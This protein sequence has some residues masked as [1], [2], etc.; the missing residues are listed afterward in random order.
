MTDLLKPKDDSEA[1]AVFRAQVI[2]PLTCR[3]HS[4]HGELREALRELAEQ[5]VTPPGHA[6]SRCYSLTTLERWYYAFKR[7][8]LAGL[9]PRSRASGFA[10]KLDDQK[11]ELLLEIRREH[12]RVST[13]LILRTIERDGRLLKGSISEPTLRRL[14]IAHGLDR[15]TLSAGERPR[16]RWETAAPN[17]LWHTDVCHGPAFRLDGR[18]VPL[19]IHALLDDHSRY[20]VAIQA[21]STERES[22]MLA[23][24]VKA[25][26]GQ[27][28]PDAIYTDNGP[29]YVGDALATLCSRLG[30]GLIHARPHDPQARGKMERFWRTLREQ[31][32]DH[33]GALSSLHDVQVRLLAWLDGHYHVTAHSSLMGKTPAQVFES[34]RRKPAPDVMLREALVVHGKR[35]LRRDAT[36]SIAG[37]DFETEQGFLAGRLVVVARSLL[38]SRE[39]P[40]IEHEDQRHVLQHVAPQ[41]H[42][43][44]RKPRARRGIDAIPFDPPGA[45]LAKATGKH[46]ED[47][48]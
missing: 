22:E 41:K 32:L 15:Q 5:L 44:Q 47:A 31:C 17:L 28:L 6:V 20:V 2:G 16:R 24:C 35:R 1:V 43:M 25:F 10:R 3:N 39:L 4:G 48:R 26:R 30:I 7:R 13:A 21:C 37:S 45:L 11:R 34:G 46:R 36:L 14:Y 8:G 40:W 19:R 27:G 38:D 29:T 33:F 23:L 12:P 42:G 18:S 9:A